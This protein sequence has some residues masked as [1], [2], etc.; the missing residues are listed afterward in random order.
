MNLSFD[1]KLD[2]I[3]SFSE[4]T[5]ID[6]DHPHLFNAYVAALSVD[7]LC[8][9]V[10]AILVEHPK[11]RSRL[12]RRLIRLL[13][14]GPFEANFEALR[15]LL[16]Q[17]KPLAQTNNKLRPAIDA[18]HAGVFEWLP[19]D[20]QHSLLE[21]WIGRGTRGAAARWLK[22][23]RTVSRLFDT[24]TAFSYWKESRDFRAARSLAH[25]AEPRFL[26][27]RLLELV[28]GCNEGWIISKAAL[29]AASIDE[30]VWTTICG[31]LPATYLYLC[32]KLGRPV[33]DAEALEIISA[34][35]SDGRGLAIWATGQ[36][37]MYGVLDQLSAV[38][39]G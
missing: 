20:E 5:W 10:A 30:E 8:N 16:L 23:T 13:S 9:V 4:Y 28:E 6:F 38:A 34:C 14:E 18:L 3:V 21:E 2:R 1:D 32:A 31:K 15:A 17:T 26:K 19:M 35:D 12:Q 24:Q 37:K 39:R 29:R 25:Q 27:E 22:A 33:K 11:L 7:E 36:M